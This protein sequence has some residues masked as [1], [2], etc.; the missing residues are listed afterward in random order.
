MNIVPCTTSQ[1]KTFFQFTGLEQNSPECVKQNGD[2][3]YCIYFDSQKK[4]FCSTI[5]SFEKVGT[6]RSFEKVGDTFVGKIQ[7][8]A[9][10]IKGLVKG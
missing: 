6:V 5:R 8:L 9:K 4:H 10:G 7:E 3:P 2:F 1:I